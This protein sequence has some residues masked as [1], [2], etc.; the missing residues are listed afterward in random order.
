MPEAAQLHVFLGHVGIKRKDP[1]YYKL[2]VLDYVLGTGP[3]FTYRLSRL[4]DREGLAYT[5]TAEIAASAGREPG[6]FTCYIGTYPDKLARVKKEILAEVDRLRYKAPTAKEVEDVKSYLT[7]SRLLGFATNSGVAAQL[8][9]V[10]RYG[11]GLNYLEDFRKAVQ[12]VTP[13][14]VQGAAKKH[15]HPTRMVLVAAGPVDAK[16]RPLKKTR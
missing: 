12:A 13:E 2:L 10:E 4:R 6:T 15:L 7:G 9:A 8:L 1:D 14:D 11:L 5:V 16:G 3:G